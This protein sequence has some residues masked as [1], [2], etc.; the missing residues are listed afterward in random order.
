MEKQRNDELKNTISLDELDKRSSRASGDQTSMSSQ[1]H[2]MNVEDLLMM[3][4]ETKSIHE[5]ADIL[6]YLF[7]TK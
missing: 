5:E 3:L 2:T 4:K 1:F 6:H 7:E